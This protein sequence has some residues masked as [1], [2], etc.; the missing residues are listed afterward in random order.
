MNFMFFGVVLTDL[1]HGGYQE[2]LNQHKYNGFAT[3]SPLKSLV[4]LKRSEPYFDQS[5]AKNITAL[6]S[7]SAYLTCVVK[8]LGN[9]TVSW[10]R[11]R[12][13]H[14]LTVAR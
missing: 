10:I 11:H 7:K 12:D 8:N 13:L 9:K 1:S 2:H 6:V 14:I 5:V 3:Q 4:N